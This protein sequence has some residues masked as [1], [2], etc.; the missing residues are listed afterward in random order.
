M[1]ARE[2]IKQLCKDYLTSQKEIAE[3]LGID[4]GNLS[5]SLKGD[6]KLST[7]LKIVGEIGAKVVVQTG[8]DDYVLRNR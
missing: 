1:T 6:M 4:E 8:S 2:L 5:K 7:F 3:A